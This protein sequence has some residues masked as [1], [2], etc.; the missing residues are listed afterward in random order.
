M[1]AVSIQNALH[2]KNGDRTAAIN[3]KKYFEIRTHDEAVSYLSDLL[4]TNLKTEMMAVESEI[5]AELGSL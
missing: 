5:Q 3:E 4:R 2:Q 1:L